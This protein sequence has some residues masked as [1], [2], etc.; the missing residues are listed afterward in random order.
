MAISPHVYCLM[1]ASTILWVVM[2]YTDAEM[3]GQAL[4]EHQC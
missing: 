2:C 3:T 1:F 4:V